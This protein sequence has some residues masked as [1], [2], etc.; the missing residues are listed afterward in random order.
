MKPKTPT[1]S[2]IS[3]VNAPE[4]VPRFASEGNTPTFAGK[5]KKSVPTATKLIMSY[6]RGLD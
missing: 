1:T 4:F 3:N 5:R 2:T 6:Y